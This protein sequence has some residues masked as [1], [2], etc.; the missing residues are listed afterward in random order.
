MQTPPLFA[1]IFQEFPVPTIILQANSP[2]F[3][4]LEVNEMFL[5]LNGRSRKALIGNGL[6]QCYP[7]PAMISE[8]SI[9]LVRRSLHQ[10]L[11]EKKTVR[12]GIQKYIQNPLK[13]QHSQV[14]YL[15]ATNKPVV[16][17]SGEI[18][19]IIRSL[20]EVTETLSIQI[21]EREITD[22]LIKN[23]K[24]LKESQRIARIGSW[25]VDKDFNVRWSPLHY[26]IF[27]TGQDFLPVLEDGIN[28]F[29]G[30]ENRERFRRVFDEAMRTGKAFDEEFEVVSAQGNARWLRLIGK[31]EMS[32]GE[33]VRMYGVAQD[34]T[35][36]KTL[37]LDLLHSR[38]QFE[39]LIQSIQGVVWEADAET[40]QMTFISEQVTNIL[41]YTPEECLKEPRFWQN[42]LH[43][44]NKE[45]VVQYT[46]AQINTLN[47][48]S[49]EYRIMKKDGSYVWL[50]TSFSIISEHTQ[51]KRVRALMI[52]V[53]ATKLLTDLEHLEKTVL[54]LT[55]TAG[56]SLEEVLRIYLEG[57]SDLFFPMICAIMRIKN[58]RMYNWVSTSLPATF[59]AVIEGLPIE[60]S[61]S[62]GM[63][64]FQKQMVIVSDIA[65]DP[66]WTGYKE[67]A[68]KENLR[69]CWSYPIINSSGEVLATLG[70]Y[71]PTI[72]EP[73]EEE[74]KV[75]VRTAS[76]LTV[77]IE[78]RY[79]SELLEE[80]NFLMKQSQ[81]L[82]HF[83]SIDWDLSSNELSWSDELYIIF[84][85]DPDT[86]ISMEK[87]YAWVH[88]DDRNRVKKAVDRLL[89]S[90][91][92]QI[93][94]ERIITP[95]GEIKYLRTWVRIKTNDNGTPIRMIGACLDI[96]GSK[97]TEAKLVANEQ[98]LR[99]ILDSQTNYVVR[100]GLDFKYQFANKKFV[101]DFAFDGQEDLT[102]KDALRTVREDQKEQVI[103]LY[104]QCIA[105]PGRVISIELEKL[106]PHFPDKATF[107]HLVCL[108]DSA[109]A[110]YEIQGIGIDISERKK[111]E[112]EGKLKTLELEASEKRYSDLFHLSPQPMYLFDTE[113]LRF[114]DVN[115]AA[116]K[117]YGYSREEFLSMTI[118]D[119]KSQ[120]EQSRLDKEMRLAKQNKVD[121]YR[122][123][124]T[125]FTKEG[126]MIHVDLHSNLIP[127]KDHSAA[128]LVLASNITDRLEYLKTL[129]VQNKKLTEIA[130]TQSHVVRAPLARIMALI[131]L[132]KNYPEL[133]E[134]NEELLGYIF[135]SAVELDEVITEISRKAEAVSYEAK[136]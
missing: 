135:T 13:D 120:E 67:L 70:M 97:E 41:G 57:I 11:E 132:I 81:E 49:H 124:F 66:L 55:S 112:E 42:H 48:F 99:N 32:N 24:F 123:I 7:H 86:E 106:S 88:P 53:T 91:E 56:V 76:I 64:A 40:F 58:C 77:I 103:D 117:Q 105:H 96:T 46:L 136:D 39:Q 71:Y 87:H 3:T 95:Q 122:A 51:P 134:E 20:K 79:S 2:D 85:V 65:N 62:C 33:F 25:E 94:E 14:L 118:K 90:K 84:G 98:R 31:G 27:E 50:Q 75:V 92:D 10:V 115:N 9:G 5:S 22:I 111:A 80:T 54:E 82:A 30:E 6:F 100:I 18:K 59:Q 34:I 133:N 73:S 121:F 107:W 93:F 37:E 44:K 130:W 47:Q 52:D 36:K 102:G 63:A 72:K 110:P 38:N 83:G 101:E 17:E 43:P 1:E 119:I 69:A 116:I 12:D 78:H 19:Y 8:E 109:G 104:N 15:Q 21:K 128:R 26:D 125:H 16:T 29:K 108:T 129:E 35:P 127:Y 61:G 126:E 23:E 4:I 60:N 113:S 89:A 74:L 68:L 114:L 28:F 131:D 45:E